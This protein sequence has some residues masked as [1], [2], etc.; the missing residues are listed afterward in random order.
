MRQ[1][2]IN[3]REYWRILNKRKFA[4]ILTAIIIGAFST[5]L[6]VLRTPVP[7]Y[8]STCSIRFEKDTTVQGVYARTISW[9]DKVDIETLISVIKSYSVMEEVARRLGKIPNETQDLSLRPDIADKIAEIQSKLEVFQEEFTNIIHIAVTDNNPIFAQKLAN[10]IAVTYRELHAK[11]QNKRGTEALKYIA[12]QLTNARRK[13]RE[14]EDEFSGFE[15]R[16]QIISIDLQ[17]ESLLLRTREIGDEIRKLND[18]EAELAELLVKLD[19]FIDYPSDSGNDFYSYSTY[20]TE[21]YK[22]A[23]D[24]L[25]KLLLRRDSLL[26]EYTSRH[27]EVIAMK[28]EIIEVAR[29]MVIIAELQVDGIYKRKADLDEARAEVKQKTN[30]LMGKKLEFNRLKRKVDSYNN[31][32]ALLEQKNQEASIR[33][34]EK[35]EEVT[36]VR[37]ALMPTSAINPPKTVATGLIGVVVG[38]ILGMVM[39]FVLETF[40][41]SLAAIEDVEETLGTQVLG[42][43]LHGDVKSIEESLQDKDKEI[44]LSHFKRGMHLVSHF[45][46][47]S[48]LAESFRALRTNIQFRGVEKKITSLAI[49]SA[50]PQ[51]GKT[52]V[53]CNLGITMA[54]AGRKTLLVESD[55]RRPGVSKAFGIELNPGLTDVL[56]GNYAFRDVVKTVTD[57][58]I[59]KMNLDEVMMTPGLDNLHIVTGGTMPPNPAELIDSNRLVDFLE[60][61]K[62]KY[63]VVIF[64][65]PPVLSATDAVILGRKADAVLLVYR[66]GAVSRGLLKRSAVQLSQAECNIVGVVL[67]DMK[68][69]VSPDFHGYKYYQYYYSYGPEGPEKEK[70]DKA[71]RLWSYVEAKK[72]KYKT[73]KEKAGPDKDS[74]RSSKKAQA[75]K[76]ASSRLMLLLVALGFLIVGL[77]WQNGVLSVG[78]NLFD[79]PAPG[80]PLK[81]TSVEETAR[82]SSGKKI[83]DRVKPA[84]SVPDSNKEVP[85]ASSKAASSH[86]DRMTALVKYPYSLRTGSFKSLSGAREAVDSLKAKG[87]SPYWAQVDMGERGKW[88]G[89]FVGHFETSDKANE[90]KQKHG[91]TGT[92]VSETPY[93]IEI[94]GGAAN[95]ESHK[96]PALRRMGGSPY[97]IDNAQGGRRLLVGAFATQTVAD[98]L[99]GRLKKAGLDSKVVLR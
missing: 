5:I 70:G 82:T 99:A 54:Q 91:L 38:L 90:L 51:E 46:P 55:F 71:T 4:V 30:Q 64:D 6:A 39:G 61:V 24:N 2:D 8:T 68:A 83:V 7:L 50:S 92:L 9:Y 33:I 45:A 53:S 62:E 65:T 44:P 26:K 95:E 10:T 86:S 73:S 17:S 11:E 56:L 42:I 31:M 84:V 13:L 49:T 32:V 76:V 97:Y 85:P 66:V 77:L 69:A 75:K 23:N 12:E 57:I 89:V 98:R 93:A 1:Y 16:S 63:N 40:D 37:P 80:K 20:A 48:M 18:A 79:R 88:L 96:N 3:L 81:E 15:R 35:P 36:M 58:I 25:L 52:T 60:E 94:R 67:N 29:R 78:A 14:A 41:T 43:I 34:A 74:S 59:G 47:Q 28:R 87:L 19:Q 21:E 72:L 27:P 22:E